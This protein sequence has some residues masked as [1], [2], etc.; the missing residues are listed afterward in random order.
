MLPACARVS[1]AK[2]Q[3]TEKTQPQLTLQSRLEEILHRRD[4]ADG[5]IKFA[6]RVIELDTGRELYTNLPDEPFIPASNMKLPV[7]AAAL[8]TFGADASFETHLAFVGDDLWLIG[9]GDPAIGDP[10]IEK[11]L[12]RVPTSVLD[13][14]ATALLKRGVT[15]IKGNL[16][17]DDGA[18]DDVRFNP[19]WSEDFH[20]DWY[21]APVSGLNF[22]D[23][24]VDV[25]VH[26]TTD[27]QPLAY[28]VM[29]PV[30][31]IQII[32]QCVTG[33]GDE[34]PSISR[35]ADSNTYTITGH[36]TKPTELKSKSVVDP[37]P[38]FADALRT[39]LEL[40]GI[41]IAG[42]TKRA[43]RTAGTAVVPAGAEI[44]AT[45]RSRMPD[46][47]WRINKSSQNMF[48]DAVFK[49]MGNGTW[50]G[51]SDAVHAFLKKAGIDDTPFNVVDGS[52]LAR[53]NRVT[54][55]LMTDLL[56]YMANHRDAETFRASMSA[57]G[58]D[59]TLR[60]RMHDLKGR[61][62]AKTGYI[63]G[64]RALSGYVQQ[65]D[66]K[67]L[68]FSI[69]FNGFRGSERPFEALQ[70]EAV[71]VLADLPNVRPSTRPASRPTTRSS[72][73]AATRPAA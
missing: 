23:N 59:G 36:C 2:D 49:L 11:K 68:A 71:H 66:G 18:L 21:A 41:T 63:G 13:D 4:D 15:Q 31:D 7:S 10:A 65:S 1:D 44:V 20:G 42:E 51:G 5:N 9:T 39:R 28:T 46:L 38:F 14:W 22:N 16:V 69:I 48:A 17:Y 60:N 40:R 35:E 50:E 27:G 62:Q 64:V 72:R 30:T 56:A 54:A 3:R 55:R 53:E 61:V 67:W 37:G 45:H 34:A 26:P 43:Q 57:A 32:N 6:A 70:D 47:M 73:R 12:G 24:C 19:H 52:G 58:V 29:P 25:T 8:D 33:G